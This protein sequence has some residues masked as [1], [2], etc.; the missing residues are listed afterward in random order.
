MATRL[1][2]LRLSELSLVDNPACPSATISVFKRDGG[3][4][5][6]GLH[7]LTHLKA[8]DHDLDDD[9]ELA[10]LISKRMD[11]HDEPEWKAQ[12]SVMRTAEGLDAYNR[13]EARKQERAAREIALSYG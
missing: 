4:D 11:R 13:S 1:K 10:A 2:K 3:I 12:E 8:S 7:G 5:I 9:R 6:D